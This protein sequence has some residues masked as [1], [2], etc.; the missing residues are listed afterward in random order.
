MSTITQRR[1]VLWAAASVLVAG[2]AAAALLGSRAQPGPAPAPPIVQV[3]TVATRRVT[4]WAEYSG[5]LA[6]LGQVAIRPG[7][8]RTLVG[9]HFHDGQQVREG[10]LLDK[11]HPE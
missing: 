11:I 5:R 4:D 1:T 10:D 2:G 8:A 7:V 9:V 6:A 3:H